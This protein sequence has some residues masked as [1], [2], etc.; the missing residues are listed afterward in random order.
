MKIIISKEGLYIPTLQSVA[1]ETLGGSVTIN[2]TK[3]EISQAE[4]KEIP[5]S[6]VIGQYILKGDQLID[7]PDF[8][9]EV[10]DVKA[11]AKI[12]LELKESITAMKS[13]IDVLKKADK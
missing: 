10:S 6:A 13:D 9:T 7:N 8:E 3:Y 12:V 5:E 1:E 4:V 11:L 2:G